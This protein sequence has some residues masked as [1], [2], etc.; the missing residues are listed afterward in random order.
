M[1]KRKTRFQCTYRG[2]EYVSLVDLYNSFHEPR[3]S[4][5][6]FRY[7]VLKKGF[8]PSAAAYEVPQ[9]AIKGKRDWQVGDT[10]EGGHVLVAKAEDKYKGTY[11]WAIRCG[12]CGSPFSAIP[13]AVN[14]GRVR[15]C[16]C[17]PGSRRR[18]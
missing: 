2:K 10:L 18:T 15:S 1:S 11:L 17:L 6:S 9:R 3:V 4:Y 16:G 7:R 8:D 14:S 5:A 13:S 12:Y